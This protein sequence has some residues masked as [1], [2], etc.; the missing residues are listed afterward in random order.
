MVTLLIA[1]AAAMES[2]PLFLDLMMPEY[3]AII[4]SVTLVLAF[5]EIIPQAMFTGPEQMKIANRLIP[6]TKALMCLL[7]PI[8]WPIAKLLDCCF[9]HQAKTRYKNKELK[10]LVELHVGNLAAESEGY[11]EANRPVDSSG[12]HAG[13]VQLIHGAIE[14]K[15][16]TIK[17]ILIGIDKVYCISDNCIMN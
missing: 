16:L 1:N 15:E 13:Q 3:A 17:D 5:G 6:F 10:A 12:L 4:I 8:S 7:L 9:G 11:G 2:L 14:L